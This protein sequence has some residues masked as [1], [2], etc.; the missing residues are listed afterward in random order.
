MG[1]HGIYRQWCRDRV[2][3]AEARSWRHYIKGRSEPEERARFVVCLVGLGLFMVLPAAVAAACCIFGWDHPFFP[4]V[5]LVVSALNLLWLLPMAV[6]Y[7]FL[8][9]RYII[10]H[11]A[12]NGLD[13][14]KEPFDFLGFKRARYLKKHPLDIDGLLTD[15]NEEYEILEYDE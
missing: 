11:I 15:N 3:G 12:V 2:I 14:P 7:A 8:L 4:A 9:V 6:R 13:A 1:I 10:D 5:W